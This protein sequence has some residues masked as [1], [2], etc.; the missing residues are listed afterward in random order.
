V[1]DF[2]SSEKEENIIW[3]HFFLSLSLSLC[4]TNYFLCIFTE[5]KFS[6]SDGDNCLRRGEYYTTNR[7]F[8]SVAKSQAIIFKKCLFHIFVINA[9]HYITKA[10]KLLCFQKINYLR[11]A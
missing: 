4:V 10:Q 2:N 9:E 8:L 6:S 5:L 1:P 3:K 11:K 7:I